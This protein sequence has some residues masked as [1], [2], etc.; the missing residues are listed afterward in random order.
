MTKQ[1][2]IINGETNEVIVRDMSPEELA[3]H[4]ATILESATR[5]AESLAKKQ[6]AKDALLALGLDSVIAA[7]IAG[8]D[9]TPTK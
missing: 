6:N 2:T 1:I 8:I 9:E 4:E 3:E 5:K 7:Q